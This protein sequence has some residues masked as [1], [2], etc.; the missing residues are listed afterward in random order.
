[1]FNDG[2]WR[3]WT[4]STWLTLKSGLSTTAEWSFTNFQGN[5]PGI[6][7]IGA[8]GVDGL[9]RYDGSTVQAFGDAP[10][11][12]KYITTYQNRLWG[13]VGKEILACALDQPDQ[14]NLFNGTEEES[15]GKEMESTR[16]ENVNGLSGSLTKLTISMPNSLHELYGSVPSDFATRLVTEDEGVSNHKSMTTLLGIM[17]FIHRN[18]IF[19]YAGGVLPSNEFSQIVGP[20]AQQVDS[21]T[22]AGSDGKKLY[23]GIGGEIL[24]YD[25]RPG[26]EAWN[27]WNGINPLHM[28][29]LKNELYIG[30]TVDGIDPI[31][32]HAVS[33]PFNNGSMAQ[34]QRWY[35]MWIIVDLAP[36]SILNVYLSPSASGEDWTLIKTVSG[37]NLQSQ[38][39][40]IPVKDFA[41]EH[42]IRMKLAGTGWARIHEITRQQRAL[43][44]Y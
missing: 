34:R 17:R 24:V 39:V 12:I 2:T 11:G 21:Q 40:M 8:N 41:M 38:R 18:G 31:Q 32:W 33:K 10:Q 16:G 28:V 36:G 29:Q 27:V 25:P 6:N 23:F 14:W 3:R 5:L 37:G 22:V 19:E 44:M 30:G 9:H 42:W 20:Y 1:V 43:P 15:Y 35:K 26:I 4:G 7:L 13:A